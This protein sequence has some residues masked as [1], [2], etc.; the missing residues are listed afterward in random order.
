VWFIFSHARLRVLAAHPVFPTP[1]FFEARFMHNSGAS[2]RGVA[3]V[4][5]QTALFEN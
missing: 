4:R 5:L 3:E 1:S 2:R